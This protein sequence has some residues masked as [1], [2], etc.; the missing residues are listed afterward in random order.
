MI[1]IILAKIYNLLEQAYIRQKD[2][3]Y[4]KQFNIHESARLGYLP[5]IIFKGNI[6]LGANSYFNSGKISTGTN[7]SVKIGNWC[8]IGHN[9]NIHAITHDPDFATG[10]EKLRPSVE[11]DVEIGNHVWIGSNCFILPGIK[12]GN[13]VVIAANAV[14]TKDI[15]DNLIVGGIP[16]KFIR[17]KSTIYNEKDQ[18]LSQGIGN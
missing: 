6:S 18:S 10:N 14:V 9:V 4:R 5:H 2:K 16:A 12:I 7:S 11:G 3:E 15:P 17:Y 1:T 8:A 13:N